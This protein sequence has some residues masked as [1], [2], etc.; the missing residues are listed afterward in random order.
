MLE[1]W[2]KNFKI[3][4]SYLLFWKNSISCIACLNNTKQSPC[5]FLCIE[6][7]I[8]IRKH[9]HSHYCGKI[10]WFQSFDG[11]GNIKMIFTSY[12]DWSYD[13]STQK[14]KD[15]WIALYKGQMHGLHC[16]VLASTIKKTCWILKFWWTKKTKIIFKYIFF[17]VATTQ[18]TLIF[19]EK[20]FHSSKY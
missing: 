3:E 17:F 12:F 15:N 16:V 20:L 9:N 10:F 14:T 18:R 8:H 7:S 6:L 2:I 11:F 13:K 5:I 1:I 19:D 4:W